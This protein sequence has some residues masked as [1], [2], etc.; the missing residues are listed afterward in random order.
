MNTI[1]AWF[2]QMS[3]LVHG[4]SVYRKPDG[5]TVNVTRMS[6]EKETGG[7]YRNDEKYV[8]QV[9]Q[10]EDGGCVKGQTRVAGITG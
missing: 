5:S 2:S 10:A 7:T 3:A 8:G 1:H 4:S 9:V 6:V